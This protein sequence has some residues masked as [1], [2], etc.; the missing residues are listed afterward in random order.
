MSLDWNACGGIWRCKDAE[1]IAG[2]V[3]EDWNRHV[4]LNYLGERRF[5]L[6]GLDEAKAWVEKCWA[7]RG[8]E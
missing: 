2:W 5:D 6:V 4:G 7:E 3:I 1:S 8:E